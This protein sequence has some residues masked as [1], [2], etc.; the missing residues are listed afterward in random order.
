MKGG[1]CQMDNYFFFVENN[2]SYNARFYSMFDEPGVVG[3]LAAFILYGNKYDFSRWYVWVIAIC[4]IF[5]F[6]LAFYTLTLIG[7]LY[8]RM[9]NVKQIA[10][11]ILVIICTITLLV[12]LYN[13]DE[14]FQ[15]SIVSR[16]IEES[17]GGS[18]DSRTGYACKKKLDSIRWTPSYFIGIGKNAMDRENLR[19]GASYQLFVLERGL[20]SLFVV[21]SCYFSF[22]K[23]RRK[24]VWMLLILFFASFLQRPLLFT[25]WQ[26]LLFNC[27]MANI[28]CVN[29]NSHIKK[30]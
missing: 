10:S 20:L 15:K 12:Y 13:N 11:A 8:Y 14:G 16:T 5:T 6:S 3:T 18:L 17:D 23:H 30:V 29:K 19:E 7:F 28:N 21:A 24:E 1:Y 27:I 25:S 9:R 26:M 22:T 2:T 4:S